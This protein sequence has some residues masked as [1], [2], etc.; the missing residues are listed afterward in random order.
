MVIYSKTEDMLKDSIQ[1]MLE[2]AIL[3]VNFSKKDGGCLGYPAA[4]LLLSIVAVIGS[5]YEGDK[6]YKI[7]INGKEKYI[8]GNTFQHF[9]ILNSEYFNLDLT[10]NFIKKLYD[11]FRSLLVHNAVI[12]NKCFITINDPLQRPFCDDDGFKNE[13]NGETYPSVAL[14]PL[15]KFSKIAVQRFIK[16]IDE[17]YP[18][19]KQSSLIEM[20]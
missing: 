9:Y 1:E 8:K 20:K 17:V 5:Y 18:K 3:C 10:E 7:M 11:N 4:I 19:S 2:A 14:I 15:L 6:N 16:K 12:A 13:K